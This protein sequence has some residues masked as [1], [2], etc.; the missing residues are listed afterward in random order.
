MLDWDKLRIF[1][2]VAQAKNITKAGEDLGVNHLRQPPDNRARRTD[3]LPL[4]HRRPRGL[5]LTEQG[6]ILLR[7]CFEFNQKSS[8][9]TPCWR[10][11]RNR[12]ASSASP[13]PFQSAHR[14]RLVPLVKEFIELYPE[15]GISPCSS[16]T[17]SW[18]FHARGRHRHPH[19][20][21]QP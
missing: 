8:P 10:H 5:L 11:M 7:T 6:E 2:A 15:V 19:A 13:S 21:S 18:T 4:F 17:A 20:N 12:R 1:Y 9:R 3:R 14:V 16:M